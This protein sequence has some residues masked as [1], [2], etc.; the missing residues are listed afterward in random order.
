MKSHAEIERERP[1]YTATDAAAVDA[2]LARAI[3][4]MKEGTDFANTLR[5]KTVRESVGIPYDEQT[6]VI[7]ALYDLLLDAADRIDALAS[8][9]IR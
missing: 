4:G 9:R 6:S 1:W 2:R 5:A 3:S 7:D 8:G